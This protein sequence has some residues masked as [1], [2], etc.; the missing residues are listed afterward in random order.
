M[1]VDKYLFFFLRCKKTANNFSLGRQGLNMSFFL[2][3]FLDILICENYI[4]K[5]TR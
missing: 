2:R 5:Y 4:I 3:E 1:V